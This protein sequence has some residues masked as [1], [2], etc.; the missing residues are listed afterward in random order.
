MFTKALVQKCIIMRK[1][2]NE[3]QYFKSIIKSA[4]APKSFY[5]DFANVNQA[6]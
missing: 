1:V 3:K 2:I 6:T 5:L 4:S